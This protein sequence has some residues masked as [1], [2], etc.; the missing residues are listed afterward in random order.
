[1]Y[2]EK[3]GDR[4]FEVEEALIKEAKKSKKEAYIMHDISE[5]QVMQD[6]SPSM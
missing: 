4:I 6:G 2:V 3:T 1:M 5:S